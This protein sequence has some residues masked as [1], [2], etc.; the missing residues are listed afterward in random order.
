LEVF[1]FHFFYKERKPTILEPLPK[2]T[3]LIV[4]QRMSKHVFVLSSSL[5]LRASMKKDT[6]HKGTK[7]YINTNKKKP[8]SQI[9][10]SRRAKY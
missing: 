1:L 8:L 6:T 3:R 4:P 2:K 9:P 10:N 5:I 7:T